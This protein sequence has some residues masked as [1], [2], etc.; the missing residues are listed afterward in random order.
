MSHLTDPCFDW[1]NL[2]PLPPGTLVW[3]KLK[4]YQPWP[5]IVSDENGKTHDKI[6]VIFLEFHNQHAWIPNKNI[7]LFTN[8]NDFKLSGKIIKKAA[9][10]AMRMCA[11][12]AEDR[13]QEVQDINND[14]SVTNDGKVNNWRKLSMSPVVNVERYSA[15]MC[16]NNIV[17]H[18]ESPADE[19]VDNWNK[20]GMTPKKKVE[21][22]CT[23]AGNSLSFDCDQCNMTFSN[24]KSLFVH[25]RNSTSELCNKSYTSENVNTNKQSH[26]ELKPF[27]CETCH[28]SFP[29]LSEIKKHKECHY[30]ESLNKSNFNTSFNNS[31]P[32]Q[33]EA[34]PFPI[35]DYPNN[36]SRIIQHPMRGC[37][38]VRMPRGPGPVDSSNNSNF[39]TNSNLSP[40]VHEKVPSFSHFPSNGARMIRPPMQGRGEMRMRGRPPMRGRGGIRMS[41]APGSPLVRGMRPMG[42]GAPDMRGT[43]MGRGA[44]GMRGASM[45]RGAPDMRGTPLGRG[46]PDMRGTPIGR[47]VPDMRG[48]PMGRGAPNMRGT[49]MR[50]GAPD[51]RGPQM[52]R[53]GPDMRGTP[54]GSGAPDIRQLPIGRSTPG[55]RGTPMGSGAPDIRRLPIGRST[56]GMR[57]TPLGSDASDIRGLPIGR[58]A[59]V[60]RGTPGGTL[61]RGCGV[62]GMQGVRPPSRHGASK[63]PWPECPKQPPASINYVR[64]D[65]ANLP[66]AP[67]PKKI[68]VEVEDYSHEESPPSMISKPALDRLQYCGISVTRQKVPNFPNDLKLPSG[69]TVSRGYS[70]AQRNSDVHKPDGSGSSSNRPASEEPAKA[71][72]PKDPPRSERTINRDTFTPEQRSCSIL[73][74]SDEPTKASAFLDPSCSKRTIDLDN[75]TPEQK[76]QLRLLGII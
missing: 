40:F 51:M 29:L 14:K 72:A 28:K 38:G 20:L 23:V 58:G 39:K 57:G 17:Q 50:R 52:G 56:P 54:M 13:L 31:P 48:T 36:G 1:S 63:G 11:M 6:H 67:K 42:C 25:K 37:G 21:E 22:N 7:T 2:G 70:A 53:C 8:D 34:T 64:A 35:R 3:A 26:T 49:P 18:N 71:P 55:M 69:I 44:P 24:S 5:A 32:V 47:G 12:D 68:K 4:G 33:E 41:G 73:P 45:G 75:F 66:P 65:R 74:T 10:T 59:P 46:A 30:E 16:N 60:M 27:S 76:Q 62:P 9:N 43:P 61:V 19:K 15:K